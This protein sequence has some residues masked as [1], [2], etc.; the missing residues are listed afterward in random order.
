[1]QSQKAWTKVG[2]ISFILFLQLTFLWYQNKECGRHKSHYNN[3]SPTQL[4]HNHS[5]NIGYVV[6]SGLEA[7]GTRGHAIT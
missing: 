1:M 3:V 5:C 7:Y 4:L 2:M 6:I